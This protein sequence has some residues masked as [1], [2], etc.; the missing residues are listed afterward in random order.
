MRKAIYDMRRTSYLRQS[1]LEQEGSKTDLYLASRLARLGMKNVRRIIDM[2]WHWASFVQGRRY[3]LF[4][5]LVWLVLDQGLFLTRVSS[6][7]GASH[8]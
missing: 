7:R 4:I 3:D 6:R 8:L 5:D 2:V 1:D